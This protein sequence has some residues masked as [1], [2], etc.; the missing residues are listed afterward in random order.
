MVCQRPT[1]E[2]K[3]ACLKQQIIIEAETTYNLLSR[4]HRGPFRPVSKL[5]SL[6]LCMVCVPNVRRRPSTYR[7]PE[8]LP[9]GSLPGLSAAPPCLSSICSLLMENGVWKV[10]MF[11]QTCFQVGLPLISVALCL[12][13]APAPCVTHTWQHCVRHLRALECCLGAGA[14]QPQLF[15]KRIAVCEGCRHPL[16]HTPGGAELFIMS[17]L[18]KGQIVLAT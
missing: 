3:P 7:L 6:E 5:D 18:N 1:Q 14:Q 12:G 15:I 10:K 9:L 17:G 4:G 8:S 2:E 16:V 13:P 11:L